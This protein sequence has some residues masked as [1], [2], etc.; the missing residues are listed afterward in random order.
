MSFLQITEGGK[1]VSLEISSLVR[2]SPAVSATRAASGVCRCWSHCSGSSGCRKGSCKVQQAHLARAFLGRLG[3][4]AAQRLPFSL[5]LAFAR[6]R[7]ARSSSIHDVD[8]LVLDPRRAGRDRA[9]QGGARRGPAVARPPPLARA[10][11]VI[12]PATGHDG[13]SVP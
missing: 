2:L 1:L 7:P 4:S 11:A 8:S 9:S 12:H 10:S 6:R 13:A 5:L 3:G